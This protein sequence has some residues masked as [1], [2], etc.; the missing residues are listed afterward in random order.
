[1][2]NTATSGLRIRA[3]ATSDLNL[4]ADWAAAEGWN[5]GLADM[6]CFASIDPTGFLVGE[7][8][9]RP[10]AI[11]S[12][13]NYSADFAFLGFYIVR[14]DLRGRGLGI[15]IWNAALAHSGARVVGLDGVVAQQENY[16]KSGFALAYRNIRYGGA[17][18]NFEA[19]CEGALPLGEVL[20]DLLARDDARCYPADR[21]T[22]L[23]AWFDA[24]GHVGR[25]LVRDGDLA[26][27]G[28][29]RPCRNGRRIG[30]LYAVDSPAAESILSALANSGEGEIFIDVPE[31]NRAA[32]ALAEE[33]GM[34]PCFE[35]AR[36]Y[37]GTIRPVAVDRIFGVT[38]LEV[39]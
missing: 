30:P 39:G 37:T 20:F 35:T 3:M 15:A 14:P 38:T 16:R 2:G 6:P 24:P 25:A 28:I 13:V 1:M 21:P 18:A 26:G 4:A 23:R 17:P 5:P 19:T 32:V 10:A 27:W 12:N 7:F 31:P 33:L 34:K 8:E 9:G 11:I 36:M 22:F 29:I